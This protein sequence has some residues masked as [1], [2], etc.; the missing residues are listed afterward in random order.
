MSTVAKMEQQADEFRSRYTAV[1]EEIGKVY[2]RAQAWFLGDRNKD[3]KLTFAAFY[4]IQYEC[5][6]A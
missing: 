1:R 5:I 4:A 3:G 2:K 6:D